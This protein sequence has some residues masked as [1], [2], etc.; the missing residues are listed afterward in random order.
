MPRVR[1]HLGCQGVGVSLAPLGREP[2]GLDACWRQMRWRVL[3]HAGVRHSRSAGPSKTDKKSQ[4][5]NHVTPL[6]GSKN[7]VT[8]QASFLGT[9]D[10]QP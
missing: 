2:D 7:T 6:R 3:E 8:Q 5:T 1:A 4:S 10:N 9:D